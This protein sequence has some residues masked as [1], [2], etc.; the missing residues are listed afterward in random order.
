VTAARDN[1]SD[2]I[3]SKASAVLSEANLS[4][5]VEFDSYSLGL[6]DASGENYLI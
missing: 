4:Y 5:R 2:F 1:E 6:F 3:A